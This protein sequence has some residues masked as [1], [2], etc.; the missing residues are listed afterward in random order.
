MI[1]QPIHYIAWRLLRR[2]L[3]QSVIAQFKDRIL[4]FDTAI[5]QRCAALHVPDPGS[6][7]DALIAATGLVHGLTIVTRNTQDFERLGVAIFNPWG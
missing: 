5:A 7:R 4:A 6:D 1:M 2:W 3:D